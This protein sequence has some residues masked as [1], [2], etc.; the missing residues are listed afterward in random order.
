MDFFSRLDA[1]L[2]QITAEKADLRKCQDEWRDKRI[3]LETEISETREKKLSALE[4]EIAKIKIKR[5]E[6]VVKAEQA[7]REHIH[8]E[9]VIERDAWR[10]ELEES[11][12]QISIEKNEL[13]R[14][15]GAISAQQ[16]E[17]MN[18]K[19]ELESTE[20]ILER[21]GELLENQWQ[22]K[23]DDL[24]DKLEALLEEERESLE[25]ERQSYKGEIARLRDSLRIQTEFLDDLEDLKRQLG[26]D[27]PSAVILKL[28]N[29]TDELK[30]LQ[31]E[32]ATRPTEEMREQYESLKEEAKRQKARADEREKQIAANRADIAE[33]ADLRLRN[34]E[35]EAENTSLAQELS[36]F[37]GIANKAEAELERLLAPY[38]KTD[39]E[40]KQK[41]AVKAII[42]PPHFEKENVQKP[43]K[44][45]DNNDE[46][47]WL[48]EIGKK[49]KDYGI[50]FNPRI[51]YAFH[52]AL[53]TFEW[54]PLTILAGVSGTGKSE[55]PRLYSY[56]GGLYF[57]PLS[58]QPNWDSQESM[59]GFFNSID[60]KF[61]AQPVLRFLAQSQQK[62][63]DKPDDHEGSYP[64]LEDAVCL[65]LLD[66]MNLARPEHYFAEF[67]SKL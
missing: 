22:K 55:L 9:I 17:L 63:V 47:K 59:L 40:Q 41:K 23:Y 46:I 18:R 3:K 29:K 50:D 39:D 24:D 19:T 20:K 65:V 45:D 33:N 5:L 8:A 2:K 35:L 48:K 14:Q 43:V 27:D 26:D 1:S 66:E 7:A 21:R 67:L 42:T 4:D 10:K 28:N 61:D 38:E 34:N 6:E 11:R 31:E 64:G 16:S 52:T 37:K 25:A 44:T 36:I 13:E 62:W 32:L 57:E 58:V 51:L 49:S 53:K 56:F 60:N 15:K 54:S 12:K 30:H